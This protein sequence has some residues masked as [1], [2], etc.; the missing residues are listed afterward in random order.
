MSTTAAG[1]IWHRGRGVVLLCLLALA[2]AVRAVTPPAPAASRDAARMII[3]ALADKPD[4]TP[5]AA[6]TPR[7]YGGLTSYSGSTRSISA[8]SEVAHDYALHEVSAWTIGPL[9]LRCML[10]EIPEQATRDELLTRLRGDARVRLAQP[11]QSFDTLGDPQVDTSAPATTS[12]D[13]AVAPAFNDPYVGLQRGLAAIGADQAQRWSSG[14]GVRV[15]VIDTGV[16]AAHPDLQKR[17]VE[18]RDFIAAGNDL[19]ARD[20]HGTEVAGVI[21]AIANNR[22]GIVGIAPKA[23]LLSYRACWPLQ[24]DAEAARCDSYT[25]ALAL[26]AAISAKAQIINLSLGGPRDPL[27]EQLAGYAVDHGIIVVG[28]MPA[29]GR[30]D[31]FPVSVPGVIAVASSED[32]SGD[33]AALA[34]PGRDILTLE[35]GGHYDYASGSSLATAQVSGA[36]ALLLQLRPRLDHQEL[37]A[38]LGRGEHAA[39]LPIDVCAAMLDLGRS[40]A[41]CKQ[42]SAAA[43]SGHAGR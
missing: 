8:A 21:G 18:Q 38:L 27:L 5:T 35:P 17:V 20:R 26:G 6:S 23:N 2:P 22:V 39:R 29:N 15:A 41:G 3:V 14:A 1:R 19:P 16:D 28:A 42:Y 4:I 13:A 34:A 7:G 31:G 12:T 25:L 10:Y 30:L 33:G 9:R 32:A 24:A 43:G 37:V 11:L 40:G 36:I